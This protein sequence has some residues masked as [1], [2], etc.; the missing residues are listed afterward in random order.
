MMRL[1]VE[2]YAKHESMAARASVGFG[3]AATHAVI[4]ALW[5]VGTLPP[6]NMPQDGTINRPVYMPPPDRVP[7]QQATV[8]RISY[9]TL[10][11]GTGLGGSTHGF[12]DAAPAITDDRVGT[13]LPDTVTQAFSPGPDSVYTVLDVDTAVVRMSSSAAPAYPL[14]MLKER[15]G[16]VVSAR[17]VVDTTGFADTS[18]FLVLSATNQ[19]FVTS[20]REALPYMRF[21]PAKIGDLAVRQLVEQQFTFRIAVDTT[22]LAKATKKP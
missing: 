4:I 18:S 10:Q 16:G 13:P 20:V 5:I 9:V 8:E 11:A 15:L 3:S 19:D 7:G 22:L 1:W 14:S 12:G 2:S 17:Y 6:P 21:R